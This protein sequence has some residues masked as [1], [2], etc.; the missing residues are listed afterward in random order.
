MT[1]KHPFSIEKHVVDG[2][3][4]VRVVLETSDEGRQKLMT[5]GEAKQFLRI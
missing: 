1:Q 4:P 5:I 2:R 3:I